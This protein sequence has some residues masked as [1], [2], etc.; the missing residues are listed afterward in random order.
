MIWIFDGIGAVL[1][2]VVLTIVFTQRSKLQKQQQ[3]VT[4]AGNATNIQA[5]RDVH[6]G[7]TQQDREHDVQPIIHLVLHSGQ[8]GS[9]GYYLNG[10]LRNVGRGIARNPKIYAPEV[11]VNVYD[12]LIKPMETVELQRVRYDNTAA[13]LQLLRDPTVRVEFE[14]EFGTK[15][16]QFGKV[17]QSRGPHSEVYQYSINGLGPVQRCN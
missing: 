6:L 9:D 14:N 16:E 17:E 13:F 7:S 4:A 11:S 1:I 15:F 10:F 12:H 5:G 2:G 8:G 3:R